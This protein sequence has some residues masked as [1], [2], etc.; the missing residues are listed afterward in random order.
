MYNYDLYTFLYVDGATMK[1]T[2]RVKE[3][4]TEPEV[5][6]GKEERRG[7]EK[8]GKINENRK[9]LQNIVSRVWILWNLLRDSFD[10]IN[11]QFCNCLYVLKQ[12]VH[13]DLRISY[14]YDGLN[15]AMVVKLFV[16]VIAVEVFCIIAFFGMIYIFWKGYDK[17]FNPDFSYITSFLLFCQLILYIFQRFIVWYTCIYDE[18][19]LSIYCLFLKVY[20][21][22]VLYFLILF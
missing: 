4:G 21:I 2:D 15:P 1:L 3:W 6:G 13:S 18:C 14:M 16:V 10:L 17:I 12:I 20:N 22:F 19:I 5:G 8:G 9:K 11:D 7:G